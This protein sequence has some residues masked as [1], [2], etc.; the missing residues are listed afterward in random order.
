MPRKRT[1]FSGS[2]FDE[3]S[4][5][6]CESVL[7]IPGPLFHLMKSHFVKRRHELRTVYYFDSFYHLLRFR[8]F[9][10]DQ[11]YR[12]YQTPAC[13][14]VTSNEVQDFKERAYETV[15]RTEPE[16]VERIW[17]PRSSG[18]VSNTLLPLGTNPEH[19]YHSP[20]AKHFITRTRKSISNSKLV[21]NSNPTDVAF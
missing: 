9:R 2:F 13:Q 6:L 20:N 12:N 8:P 5:P 14:L 10:S 4:S 19:H 18:F 11:T 16:L 21:S 17:T 3:R 1:E 7:Q 15:T